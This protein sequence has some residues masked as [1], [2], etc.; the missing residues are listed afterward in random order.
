MKLLG[1]DNSIRKDFALIS[2][3]VSCQMFPVFS[4]FQLRLSQSLTD[5]SINILWDYSGKDKDEEW[6]EALHDRPLLHY[7]V[8][9]RQNEPCQRICI[10][11]NQSN[12]HQIITHYV[13]TYNNLHTENLKNVTVNSKINTAMRQTK[14]IKNQSEKHRACNC[15]RKKRLINRF[16]GIEVE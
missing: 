6:E 4:G 15:T 3:Y 5:T 14:S 10:L 11:Q 7:I 16:C 1:S 13:T 12:Q 8:P 9:L 2:G